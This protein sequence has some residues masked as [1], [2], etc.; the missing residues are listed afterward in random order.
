MEFE[1]VCPV[2]LAKVR[3]ATAFVHTQERAKCFNGTAVDV[4]G[5]GQKFADRRRAACFVNRSGITGTKEQLIGRVARLGVIPKECSYVALKANWQF[6]D[7]WPVSE[8]ARAR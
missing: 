8:T 3:P 4:Q 7:R 1:N 2:N 6:G 5:I